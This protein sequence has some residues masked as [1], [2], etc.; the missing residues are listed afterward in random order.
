MAP[1]CRD[2]CGLWIGFD[3]TRD[4]TQRQIFGLNLMGELEIRFVD[5][6]R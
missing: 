2:A 4:Q 6:D 1:S 5:W 3:Q